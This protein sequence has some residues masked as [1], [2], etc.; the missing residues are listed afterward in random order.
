MYHTIPAQFQVGVGG[1]LIAHLAESL[2]RGTWLS[3]TG[4]FTS[5]PLIDYMMEERGIHVT[6]TLM[7]NRIAKETRGLSDDRKLINKGRGS[8]EMTVSYCE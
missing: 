4:F 2:H 7:K 3:V 1:R 8:C 6:G 5:I